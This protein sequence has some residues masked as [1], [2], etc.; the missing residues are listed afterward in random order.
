[1]LVTE[2]F[3]FRLISWERFVP[4]TNNIPQFMFFPFFYSTF[5]SLQPPENIFP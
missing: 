4:E 2:Q 1:M 3:S 5:P